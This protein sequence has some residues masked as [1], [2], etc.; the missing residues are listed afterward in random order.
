MDGPRANVETHF[1]WKKKH[2]CEEIELGNNKA[3][4]LSTL[5]HL[6]SWLFII[7]LGKHTCQYDRDLIFTQGIQIYTLRVRPCPS[8][9]WTPWTFMQVLLMGFHHATCVYF[10]FGLVAT[11]ENE[12]RGL[13]SEANL[14]TPSP[15]WGLQIA[16]A[17][18]NASLFEVN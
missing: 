18:W 9:P 7:R 1:F 17:F 4:N 5:E 16:F 2:W 14:A 13:K 15:F 6:D 11:W 3:T 8:A 10:Y 12:V